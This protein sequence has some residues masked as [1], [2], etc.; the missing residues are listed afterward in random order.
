MIGPNWVHKKKDRFLGI[1]SKTISTKP[2]V[3][4]VEIGLQLGRDLRRR[5]SSSNQGGVIGK[6]TKKACDA[7][8]W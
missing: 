5:L 4:S 8:F 6:L 7:L 1:G 2:I 3:H